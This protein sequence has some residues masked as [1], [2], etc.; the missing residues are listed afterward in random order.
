MSYI[1]Y[2][3]ELISFFNSIVPSYRNIAPTNAEFPYMIYTIEAEDFTE[4]SLLNLIVYSKSSSYLELSKIIEKIE[5]ELPYNQGKILDTNSG[6][7]AIFRGSPFI[8]DYPQD[9]DLIKAIYINIEVM[10]NIRG[11]QK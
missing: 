3:S 4:K 9:N 11:G 5:Q 2:C 6:N 1:E 10:N 7:I 8:Q